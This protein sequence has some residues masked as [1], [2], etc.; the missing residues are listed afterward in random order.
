MHQK[1]PLY[2]SVWTLKKISRHLKENA[3]IRNDKNYTLTPCRPNDPMVLDYSYGLHDR[4]NKPEIYM[5]ADR[6]SS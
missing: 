1:N 4:Q 6:D 3:G 5:V 2:F